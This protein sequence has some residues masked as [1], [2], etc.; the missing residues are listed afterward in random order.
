[1]RFWKGAFVCLSIT[2]V[3]TFKI[4]RTLFEHGRD[5]KHG[6][7]EKSH[8]RF[9]HGWRFKRLFF[10]N[11]MSSNDFLEGSIISMSIASNSNPVSYNFVA[12]YLRYLGG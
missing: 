5:F 9:K 4:H 7:Q 2:S 8:E 10:A 3:G 6:K 1:M 12:V 11:S